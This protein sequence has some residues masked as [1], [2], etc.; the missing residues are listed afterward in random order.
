[1][2][3]SVSRFWRIGRLLGCAAVVLL[4]A[5][6]AFAQSTSGNIFGKVVDNQGA[7]LPGVTVTLS[8]PGATQVFVTDAEGNFRFLG[9]S[10]GSFT[11]SAELAGFGSVVRPNVSVNV[12][13][14]SNITMTL[15]PALEQ[16]ITVTAETPLLD[17]R[18]TGTGA[19]VTDVELQEV[20]TA[21]DPW[22]VLGQVPGVLLDRINV[23][24]NES[25]QQTVFI[26][27]GTYDDQN[28]FNVDGVQIT[29]MG[30]T[31]SSPTYYDF[32]AFE[33]MQATTGGTDPRIQ[34]AGVQLNLVTKR[35]TND[36]SGSARYFWTDNSLQSDPSIPAEAQ[37]YLDSVNEIENIQDRGLEVGGPIVKDRL[38][39][40]GAYG[41]NNIDNLVAGGGHDQTLLKNYNAKL[42]A[43][44]TSKNSGVVFYSKGDKI[45]HGRSGG[46]TR[47][48]ET[49]WEQSGPTTVWKFED[50]HIFSPNFYLT[51]MYSDIGGGF[52]LTPGGGLDQNAWRDSN[53]VWHDSF[54]SYST[55]RPQKIY[56]GDASSF[57][58][59]GDIS[60]E[61]KFGFGY[62]ETPITSLSIWGGDG[63]FILNYSPATCQYF[64]ENYGPGI[65]DNCFIA[66]LNRNADRAYGT[67]YNDAYVGDTMLIGD[68]TLQVGLRYDKQTGR[69][70][71]SSVPANTIDANLLPAIDYP[72]DSKDLEW[73]SVS[74]RV[75][76][77]YAVGANNSTLLRA[78]Y[79]RYADQLG[80]GPISAGNPFYYLSYFGY[81]GSDTNGDHVAQA[82]EI[83]FNL[84]Y[85]FFGYVDPANPGSVE[86]TSRID[87]NM[88]PPKTDEIILGVEHELLPEFTVGV[89]YTHRK[90]DNFV[91][92]RYEK[93]RGSGDFYTSADYEQAGTISGTLPNGDS[94]TMPY[95]DLKSGEPVP[96][97][98]VIGNRPDYNQ[99][100]DG[101]ELFMV[102]RLSNK[103]MARGNISWN[104]WKQHV[105]ADGYVDPTR[106][107]GSAGCNNCDDTIVFAQSLG[108]GGK[109]DVFLNSHWAYNVTG[110]Y[111]LP[112][113]MTVGA[114]LTGRQG[115]PH[116]YTHT[117]HADNESNTKSV[118][119]GD[120][121][122]DRY[123]S[124]FDLD[125]RLAKEF[126]FGNAMG[127]TISA[128][129]FNVTDERTVL[130]RESNL[131][132]TAATPNDSANQI[133]ELM[134]PRVIRFGARLSF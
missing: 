121:N 95:Y 70:N 108:S 31:G 9:L 39:L 124:L 102:K 112:W 36:L 66:Q 119:V 54:Y 15:T 65:P 94:Y 69:N 8:G 115:Y 123:P 17:I 28:N 27:K 113:D 19:T 88:D 92:S 106:L 76:L 26:G 80:S 105:G 30:A 100:Y 97:F 59:T 101:I 24:G 63:N 90:L 40:W 22:V 7:A 52:G 48:P 33:E 16:T 131:Y 46:P 3:R 71:P 37:S 23:G 18:K 57:F 77:T 44:I 78:A 14:N 21:R 34:T 5:A 98:Q 56:R 114:S 82:N 41:R 85:Y 20:P 55:D 75:G 110:L 4:I 133:R 25:G 89:N 122:G 53:R 50:T 62:R 49:A 74:P 132:E 6:G 107:F 99:T 117:V 58:D 45:K 127:L 109:G 83:F 134:S 120:I 84:G 10:P 116:I 51:A 125:L 129:V 60:H 68:M 111:Q 43:Q 11:L 29:D 91:W 73:T 103:W 1:M 12:G 72:G 128:D 126:R 93:S 35:G 42:N 79:N 61:L 81:F 87:Y 96:V 47:P 86:A 104:D 67:K 2:N 13:R 64:N 32:D 118:I 130:Q 38:W